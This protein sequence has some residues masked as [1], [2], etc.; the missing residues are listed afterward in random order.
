MANRQLSARLKRKINRYRQHKNIVKYLQD[1][2]VRKLQLGSGGNPLP[3]WLNSDLEASGEVIYL[4]IRQRFPFA[5]ETFA[6][7]FSEHAIEHISYQQGLRCLNECFRV[8]QKGGKI[9]IG[10][11]NLAFLLALYGP[12]K[13]D[14]QQRYLT[15]SMETFAARLEVPRET[16][17][18]NNFFRN[19]GHEF[20]YDYETLRLA[21]TQ[22]GFVNIR[23]VQVLESEDP[24]LRGLEAHGHVI[25][26]EFN[27]LETMVAEAAKP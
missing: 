11:P 23:Q 14:C 16:F 7:I 13:S 22:A 15:W 25:P 2:S 20:I 10:T 17:V 19:W 8:L 5:N 18:I 26:P 1:H 3:G 27:R 6:Y 9:R 12:D 24:I 21:L 4:D